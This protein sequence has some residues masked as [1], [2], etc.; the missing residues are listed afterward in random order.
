[1]G[2]TKYARSPVMSTVHGVPRGASPSVIPF[3]SLYAFNAFHQSA[4]AVGPCHSCGGNS[5]RIDTCESHID[6]AVSSLSLSRLS[7]YRCTAATTSVF[8][9]AKAEPELMARANTTVK[10]A[11][12]KR[13]KSIASSIR[14]TVS[15]WPSDRI[16][17]QE[18]TAGERGLPFGAE[19][20]GIT[21]RTPA[22]ACRTLRC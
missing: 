3:F 14:N 9:E 11:A 10:A 1:M 17:A 2:A 15:S 12:A 13:L 8:S 20:K 19:R 4:H 5:S 21:S 7:R 18:Y 22:T 6:S 16:D